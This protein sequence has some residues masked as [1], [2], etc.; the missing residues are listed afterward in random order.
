MHTVELLE[1]AIAAARTLGFSI[2]QE[3]L[4]GAGGACE[5]AGKRW[6]FID[7]SLTASEQLEQVTEGLMSHPAMQE[8]VAAYSDGLRRMLKAA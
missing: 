3:W 4:D 7:L 8:R 6:L 5:I 1:E 2:R